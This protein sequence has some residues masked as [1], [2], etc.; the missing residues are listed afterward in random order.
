MDKMSLE[1][2]ILG[3]HI[4][5]GGSLLTGISSHR[6]QNDLI[7]IVCDFNLSLWFCLLIGCGD[8]LINALPNHSHNSHNSYGKINY[9]YL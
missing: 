1:N 9:K 2:G 6:P 7:I 4:I 5:F 3:A 8:A